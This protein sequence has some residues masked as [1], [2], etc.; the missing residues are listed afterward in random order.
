MQ[1]KKLNDKRCD[2]I[3]ANDIGKNE[4]GFNSRKNA[5]TIIYNKNHIEKLPTQEKSE[6]AANLVNRILRNFNFDDVKKIN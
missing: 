1:K 6:I 4:I 2:W 5:V 3:V